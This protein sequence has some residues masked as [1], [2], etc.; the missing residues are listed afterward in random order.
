MFGRLQWPILHGA[1]YIVQGL[2]EEERRRAAPAFEAIVWATQKTMPCRFCRRSFKGFLEEEMR[3]TGVRSVAQ[4]AEEG[5]CFDV[6]VSLH[7]RVSDKLDAQRYKVCGLRSRRM[8]RRT[9]DKIYA[10]LTS[11]F[12]PR[13]VFDLLMIYG[14][15]LD[16]LCEGGVAGGEEA[17][18]VVE[19]RDAF[20]RMVETFPSLLRLQ[21]AHDERRSGWRTAE[22]AECARAAATIEA[23]AAGLRKDV[24]EE[25]GSC[26]DA[27]FSMWY[28]SAGGEGAGEEV[29]RARDATLGKLCEASSHACAK[30]T[31]V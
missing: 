20:C 27:T 5:R 13:T 18:D 30:E 19:A 9:V 28:A 1:A 6:T 16:V 15:N 24:C 29:M 31:C 23:S 14:Y 8:P 2:A 7:D 25:G 3:E 4:W 22:A 12:T 11:Y 26:F 10:S 21:A 17:C